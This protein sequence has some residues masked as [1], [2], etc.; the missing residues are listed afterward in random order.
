MESSGQDNL[1][2]SE[3]IS[4][5]ELGQLLDEEMTDQEKRDL[6]ESEEICRRFLQWD[7]RADMGIDVKEKLR[8]VLGREDPK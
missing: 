6:E 5:H 1:D 7:L 4:S 3:L 2:Q 8:E